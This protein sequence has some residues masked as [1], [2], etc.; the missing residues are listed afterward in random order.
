MADKARELNPGFLEGTVTDLIFKGVHYEM[1][2]EANGYTWLVHSTKL[3]PVGSR[4]LM[5]LDPFNIQIMNKP[6]SEDEQAVNST[7]L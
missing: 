7:D 4:V 6:E 3:F 5:N 1:D 2:V